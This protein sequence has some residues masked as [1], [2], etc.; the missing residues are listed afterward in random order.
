MLNHAILF[1]S[2]RKK[3]QAMNTITSIMMTKKKQI[4][5]IQIMLKSKIRITI[6]NQFQAILLNLITIK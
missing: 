2:Y 3:Q 4:Q 6:M 5:I 1:F